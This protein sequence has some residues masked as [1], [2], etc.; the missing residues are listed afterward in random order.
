MIELPL[1][2]KI[3][4]VKNILISYKECVIKEEHQF[5]SL[6]I[7]EYIAML[8]QNYFS[9]RIYDGCKVEKHP[10]PLEILPELLKYKPEKVNRL[11]YWFQSNKERIECLEKV[12]IDL[13]IQL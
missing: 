8:T 2:K 13:Q 4:L 9:N 11:G 3:I 10:S 5:L 6:G 12:L 1:D 7:C